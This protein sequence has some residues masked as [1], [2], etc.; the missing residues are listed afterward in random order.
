[1]DIINYNQE[2]YLEIVRK[3]PPYKKLEASFALYDFARE[4]VAAELRLIK[5]QISEAELKNELKKR[6]VSR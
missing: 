1:M 6:F 5:P 2:K 4:R 3:L